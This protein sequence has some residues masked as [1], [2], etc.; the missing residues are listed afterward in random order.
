M[1]SVAPWIL[2]EPLTND[3]VDRII[4]EVTIPEGVRVDL[5]CLEGG[6]QFVERHELDLARIELRVEAVFG[7][8][9]I[10]SGFVVGHRGSK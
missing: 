1:T 5:T 4:S 8:P 3:Q 9:V 10:V 6:S 2:K 7:V